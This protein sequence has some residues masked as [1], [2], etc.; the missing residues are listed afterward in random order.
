MVPICNAN[1]ESIYTEKT[2]TNPLHAINV[3]RKSLYSEMFLLI[4]KTC[5]NKTE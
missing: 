1:E 3:A 2:G 5:L 4:F